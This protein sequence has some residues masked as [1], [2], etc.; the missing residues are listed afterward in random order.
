M[1]FFSF[2]TI[3]GLMGI[4]KF[5]HVNSYLDTLRKMNS[6]CVDGVIVRLPSS[7]DTE[8][9]RDIVNE[10]NRISSGDIVTSFS[11]HFKRLYNFIKNDRLLVI[12]VGD[13]AE[14]PILCEENEI[15]TVCIDENETNIINSE[16]IF[17]QYKE[18]G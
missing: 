4:H 16:I 5:I 2:Y 8:K 9:L 3:F 15:D 13:K 10:L 14:I 11:L 1:G 12:C 18:N 17:K 7:T 6:K